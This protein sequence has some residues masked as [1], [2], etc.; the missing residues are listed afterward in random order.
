MGNFLGVGPS[1]GYR[2][3]LGFGFKGG[4]LVL[5]GSFLGF[6]RLEHFPCDSLK[7]WEFIY[8]TIF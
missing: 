1:V 7:D 8:T 6:G 4:V 2:V 3:W 5:F